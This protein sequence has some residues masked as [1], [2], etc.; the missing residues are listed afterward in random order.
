M[1]S[2]QA[3]RVWSSTINPLVIDLVNLTAPTNVIAV[4]NVTGNGNLWFTVSE[5]GGSNPQ[6]VINGSN[7][8]C[9]ASVV[10]T[11]IN[12]RHPGMY[13]SIVSLTS[14]ASVTYTVSVEDNY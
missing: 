10:G 1:A 2:G 12:V 7:T 4:T 9:A 14:S 3:A 13:G 5:P 11:T 8:F 6:P